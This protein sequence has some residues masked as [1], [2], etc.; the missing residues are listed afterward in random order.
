ML[1]TGP[2][3]PQHRSILLHTHHR[4]TEYDDD[5]CCCVFFSLG[6][7][8][9]LDSVVIRKRNFSL[10]SSFIRASFLLIWRDFSGGFFFLCF[11]IRWASKNVNKRDSEFR[12]T[13]DGDMELRRCLFLAKEISA[14]MVK[15]C[16]NNPGESWI[17][18][19][20]T[21]LFCVDIVGGGNVDQDETGIIFYYLL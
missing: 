13:M 10:N 3:L 2:D 11:S 4:P 5:A 19:L 17:F 20:W 8:S 16:A 7:R 21:F 15:L 18:A 14:V 12:W 6:R 1:N 9:P